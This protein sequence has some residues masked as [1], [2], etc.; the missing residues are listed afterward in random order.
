MAEPRS[1]T[2]PTPVHPITTAPQRHAASPF[3]TP[4]ARHAYWVTLGALGVT[5]VV[6]ALGLLWYGNPVPP[7]DPAF[8]L[9]AE[10]RAVSIGVMLMVAICQGL[11]TVAFQTVTNNRILTPS[12]MGFESLYMVLQTGMLFFAGA[13]GLIAFRGPW[14]FAAQIALMML[15]AV[16]LYTWLLSG[17]FGNLQIMLLVG[18]IIGAGLGSIST[19]MQRLL[20]PSE[21]D[22]LTARLFGSVNNADPAT[23][24]IAI[25]II[26][27]CAGALV[28]RSRTLNVLAL[29]RD[30]S[31]N[32]GISHKR[33][34]IINLTFIS[35][36]M[37]VSTSL[38]GPMTFFGF[39][40][41]TLSYQF[42]RTHD[43]RFVFP[44]A[45]VAGFVVLTG[46]YFFMNHVFA[47][48]GVVSIIIE[49]VGG[50]TFLVVVLR[51]GRL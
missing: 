40:I 25:P 43:H 10:R 6:F 22:L 12:I 46:A 41:A 2:V 38:V 7:D 24:P 26:V 49:L 32:L 36:L 8:W 14:Q 19:F 45:V 13:A 21:F 42:A 5:A 39:L 28:L 16:F 50:L 23:F 1:S 51:R 37:A 48:Q 3:A 18:I 31:I 29:G 27:I 9:I 15:L 44:M 17:R 11:A 34:L 4:S 33:E 47:A 30:I 35:G 20:T